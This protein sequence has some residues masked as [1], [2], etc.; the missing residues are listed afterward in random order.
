MMQIYTATNLFNYATRIWLLKNPI[1]LSRLK[2]WT[3]WSLHKIDTSL[4]FRWL[5]ISI[6]I[7]A[8]A[9]IPGALW[10]G[11]MTPV[12]TS[13]VQPGSIDI[14]TYTNESKVVWDKEFYS[15][16]GERRVRFNVPGCMKGRDPKITSCPVPHLQ[17]PLLNS[18]STATTLTGI[19]RLHPK[20][21]N[22][23]WTYHGRSYGVGSSPGLM[24]PE[25][26]ASEYI[27]AYWYQEIGY[28]STVKCIKN[29]SSQYAFR[30]KPQ[31][32]DFDGLGIWEVHGSLPNSPPG[33]SELY[34]SVAWG[35]T[36][37]HPMIL[38]WSAVVNQEAPD[39]N[40]MAIAAG[41][42]S[43]ATFNQTQCAVTFTP[44][45]FDVLVNHTD[46]AISVTPL[47]SSNKDIEPTG[48][49]TSNI[50][51]SLNLLARMTPSLYE[52]TLANTL[53]QN[54]ATMHARY[55]LEHGTIAPTD[56]EAITL[57][58]VED[59]FTAMIDDLLVAFSAS[60]L[61][62][63]N[64]SK[65][66]SINAQLPALKIGDEMYTIWCWILNIVLLMCVLVEAWRT[67]C[68]KDLPKFNPG[69]IDSVVWDTRRVSDA[70][71]NRKAKNIWVM[72]R[73]DWG[74]EDDIEMVGNDV[75]ENQDGDEEAC[76]LDT[77]QDR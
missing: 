5:I 23:K 64:S 35:N 66:V 47:S 59:S 37:S 45:R 31:F 32:N 67:D 58:A 24:T 19:P 63:A 75:E 10:T 3:A 27:P 26:G 12:I 41:D 11:S 30:S 15:L 51:Y 2:A 65:P 4:P 28:Q 1:E 14:P 39:K 46:R 48:R 34:W 69:E 53:L 20:L 36:V 44:T 74:N 42:E 77:A 76:L 8:A 54:A 13:I 56:E 60:Q 68:W 33:H 55:E 71:R 29:T 16:P 7:F 6:I 22:P 40:M 62:L 61:A 50:M 25:A 57:R 43:Y 38:A 21:D 49:L 52:S 70:N 9:E 72:M 73:D 18:A 17:G